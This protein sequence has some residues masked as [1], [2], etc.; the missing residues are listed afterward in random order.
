[1]GATINGRLVGAI[2]G[3]MLNGITAEGWLRW[4][5]SVG[6]LLGNSTLGLLRGC[7]DWNAWKGLVRSSELVRVV[8]DCVEGRVVLEVSGEGPGIRS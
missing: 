7:S 3:S 4:A 8:V 5:S 2:T 6:K 1:M